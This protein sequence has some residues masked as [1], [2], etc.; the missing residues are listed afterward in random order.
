[1]TSTLGEERVEQMMTNVDAGGE[2][3]NSLL[4]DRDY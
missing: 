1:M 4:R 2:G 3:K